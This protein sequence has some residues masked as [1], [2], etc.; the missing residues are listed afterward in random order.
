VNVPGLRGKNVAQVAADAMGSTRPLNFFP[1][2]TKA[3]RT[4]LLNHHDGD[5]SPNLFSDR[6][7][8]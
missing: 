2:K 3:F 7:S 5:N 8:G 4:L 1:L 6:I